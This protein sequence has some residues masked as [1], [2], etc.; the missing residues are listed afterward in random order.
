MFGTTI[1]RQLLV[2]NL[3]GIALAFL[4]GGVAFVASHRLVKNSE[5][6][7]LSGS[8][9]GAHMSADMMHDA[10]RS[11]VLAALL[12]GVKQDTGPRKEIEADLA[13][14]SKSFKEALAQLQAMPLDPDTRQAVNKVR[15]ALDAYIEAAAKVVQLAFT[16]L[17]AAEAQMP[18]F[19][20]AFKTL[21]DD[22][23]E[24]SGLIE[25]RGAEVQAHSKRTSTQSL[26]LIGSAAILGALG[27]HWLSATISLRVAKPVRAAV[28]VAQRVA[29]GDLSKPVLIEGNG[30]SASLLEALSTMQSQLQALVETVSK[31]SDSIA[32]GS[33]EIA[34]GNTDL[35][36][37][38]EQTAAELQRTAS[39]M[40]TLTGAVRQ[41][42]ETARSATDLAEQASRVASKGGEVVGRVVETMS[43][44][45]HASQRIAD[46]IGVIDSIAFQTNILALNAAVEAARAGEQGRGFAVVA[47]EVRTLAQRSAQAARQI[48]DLIGDSVSKVEAGGEQVAEAGR[49]MRD[50]VEQV[51]KV[52]HMI[53]DINRS[54]AEQS[55]DIARVGIAIQQVDRMTQQNAA[56]VEESAAA[57]D[58]LKQ[59]AAELTAVIHRFQRQ[60]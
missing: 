16:D 46:I 49:T 18:A 59:Q 19:Q 36:Q 1:R 7:G 2:A 33:A 22:M 17:P 23:E 43:E 42:A 8:A 32:T 45:N 44:I 14:H 55:D 53:S 52:A 60:G 40:D 56:L 25:A 58:S 4:I 57:A 39:T 28:A 9:L 24:L 35:S 10:L 27:L 48:K 15:P 26:W 11:D 20:A 12:A 31:T 51:Q 5:E 21:E 29:S 47:T 37:R 6:I 38:T 54:T 13:D 50:I 30:E 41:S 34:V 3:V